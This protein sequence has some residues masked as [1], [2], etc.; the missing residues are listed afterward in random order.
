MIVFKCYVYFDALLW[1]VLEGH[2]IF[3]N[4]D[5]DV[6]THAKNLYTR[7]KAAFLPKCA[8]IDEKMR[9]TKTLIILFSANH[10][11][12]TDRHDMTCFK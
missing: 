4:C 11:C 2:L 6:T 1:L 9:L 5:I 12:N 7:T 3:I 8:E 10:K